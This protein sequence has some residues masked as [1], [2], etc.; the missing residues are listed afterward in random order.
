LFSR[1]GRFPYGGA[2]I[3]KRKTHAMAQR[4]ATGSYAA[5]KKRPSRGAFFVLSNDTA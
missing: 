2:R 4:N 5:N 1:N 3:I